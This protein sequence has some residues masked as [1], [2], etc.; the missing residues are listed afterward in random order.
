MTPAVI[1]NI[2]PKP[3]HPAPEC[4]SALKSVAKTYRVNALTFRDHKHVANARYGEN[5]QTPRKTRSVCVWRDERRLGR[6]ERACRHI[7]RSLRIRCIS[8]V[9]W[10]ASVRRLKRRESRN[11]KSARSSWSNSEPFADVSRHK[12][13]HTVP[14]ETKHYYVNAK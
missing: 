7:A 9:S 6:T 13:V 5:I 10:S 14:S 4:D 8:A 11:A 1:K 2:K 12:S 3:S